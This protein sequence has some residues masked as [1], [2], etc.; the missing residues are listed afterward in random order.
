MV[1]KNKVT[2]L[3]LLLSLFCYGLDAYSVLE[4]PVSWV[5]LVAIFTIAI[6]RDY[7]ILLNFNLYSLLALFLAPSLINLIPLGIDGFNQNLLLRLFNIVSF[8]VV[9]HFAMGYF[10][11]NSNENF[12]N[13]LQKL[14]L[15]FSVYAIYVYFAQIYDLPE[16]I[17]NRSNTGLLGD[18]LQTTFWQ[19]EPHRAMGSFR[20]PVL[21]SSMLLPLYLLYLFSAEKFN[22]VTVI[23]T[24][25]AIGL[26][27]SDL[28][29]IYCFVLLV[30]LTINYF[31]RKMIHQAI[32]P[33][34]LILL[35]SLIG[36]K[37]CDLNPQSE[38]CITS[39]IKSSSI[40]AV[41]F[42]DIGETLA[43]GSDRS[44][45]VD[46]FIFSFKSLS[47]QGITNINSGFSNYLSQ[48]I[49]QEM[50]FTNRSLP[51][52]LLKRFEAK[53]FGTGNYSLLKYSPNVQN[54]FVNNALS[55]GA[56]FV[57]VLFVIFMNLWISEKKDL[58]FYIFLCILLF[59]S[60]TP[61][62]EFN[63]FSALIIGAGYN[64]ILKDKSNR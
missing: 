48:E 14:I 11:A 49:Q 42:S 32:Y 34:L 33:I 61:I 13:L 50:Y 22:I 45:V 57:A 35:F 38:D 52:Y 18:S 63:T 47:P 40:E 6:I 39:N 36:I 12:L 20:E 64:M 62:E 30:V 15:I 53:N 29:R 1:T 5:G 16:V 17:R 9:I 3:L 21:L 44:N 2:D 54:L 8:L 4:I 43:I 28:V 24:S 7:K 41:I 58:N 27:R 10:N 46:Y 19:Y 55:L 23:V 26:T 31:K 37:E 60:I 51:N 56:P 25:L 59:F